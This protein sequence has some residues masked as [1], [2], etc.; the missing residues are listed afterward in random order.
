M[1][2]KNVKLFLLW[3]FLL[4]SCSH[5]APLRTHIVMPAYAISQSFCKLVGWNL[6]LQRLI[7]G[8]LAKSEPG[9][10]IAKYKMVIFCL[11]NPGFVENILIAHREVSPLDVVWFN[12]AQFLTDLWS[13][14]RRPAKDQS[15]ASLEWARTRSAGQHWGMGWG[16]KDNY[17]L[18]RS[19]RKH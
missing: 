10:S 14:Q 17:L 15:S 4:K 12:Q 16:Q 11:Y 5:R 7:D 2:R 3:V 19:H 1:N 8:W 13:V 9:L 6:Y 18:L